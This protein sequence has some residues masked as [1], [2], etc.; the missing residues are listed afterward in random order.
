METD[1]STIAMSKKSVNVSYQ[2]FSTEHVATPVGD[3]PP[4]TR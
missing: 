4:A 1:L 3:H 2:D